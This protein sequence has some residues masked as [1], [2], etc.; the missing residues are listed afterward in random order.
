MAALK[1][2]TPKSSAKL[3][4]KTPAKKPMVAKIDARKKTRSKSVGPT[5]VKKLVSKKTSP[6]KKPINTKRKISRIKRTDTVSLPSNMS[7]R[8]VEKSYVFKHEF[9][10]FFRHPMYRIAYVVREWR[11]QEVLRDC[12]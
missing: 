11:G 8:A 5:S 1:K 2:T 10:K 9:D 6:K 4:K 7:L 3:V 12:K